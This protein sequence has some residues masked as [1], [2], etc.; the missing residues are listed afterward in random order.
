MCN[1][2]CFECTYED[3]IIDDVTEEEKAEQKLL[4]D[5]ARGNKA[6]YNKDAQ[7]RY[8]QTDK[9]KAT[10]KRYNHS[11]KGKQAR[12]KYCKSEKGKANN[13]RKQEKRIANGKNAEACKRYYLKKKA[14]KVLKS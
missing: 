3:C 12:E 7:K 2:N 1:R 14:E 9:G 6:Y 4:D 13:K 8:R 11:D 10:Q 5:Y